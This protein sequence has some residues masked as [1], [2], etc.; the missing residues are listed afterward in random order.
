MFGGSGQG[1]AVSAERLGLNEERGQK[2]SEGDEDVKN[3]N[4]KDAYDDEIEL[5]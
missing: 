2:N 4:S 1:H 5:G 3:E